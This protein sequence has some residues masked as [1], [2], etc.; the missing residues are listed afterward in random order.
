MSKDEIRMRILEAAG[1]IFAEKGFETATVRD[2]C[3]AAGVN[4]AAINYYFGDK[5]KLYIEAVKAA[6]DPAGDD[7]ALLE[8]SPGTPPRQMLRDYIHGMAK[9]ILSE[10]APWQRQLMMREML[11]PTSAC[12]ELVRSRIHARFGQLLEIL[13]EILPPDVPPHKR[14]KI[15]FS[16]VGQVLHY[17]AAG[18]VVEMLVGERERREHYDTEAVAEHIVEVMLA[19]LGL[20]PSLADPPSNAPPGTHTVVDETSA[21]T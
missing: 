7:D 3:Q 14:H 8:W 6:H 17:H 1:P 13:D 19:A 20:G 10:R 16:V 21:D 15:A 18:D 12:R 5:E 2:I 9:R 11:H 4:V